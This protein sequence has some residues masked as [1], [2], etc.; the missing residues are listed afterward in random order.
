MM[1]LGQNL[2]HTSDARLTWSPRPMKFDMLWNCFPLTFFL[3]RKKRGSSSPLLTGGGSCHCGVLVSCQD[4]HHDHKAKARLYG[5]RGL[6][7]VRGARIQ[8]KWLHFGVFSRLALRVQCSPQI[9][10]C[11][12]NFWELLKTGRLKHLGTNLDQSISA[13]MDRSKILRFI[14][15]MRKCWLFLSDVGLQ[16]AL[17]SN[18]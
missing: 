8:F 6:G 5:R 11:C 4:H 18:W 13:D 1:F 16:L 17:L 7:W 10:Y 12:S 3:L 2:F 15:T 9:G 14:S